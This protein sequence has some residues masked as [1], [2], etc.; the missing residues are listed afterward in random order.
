ME[1]TWPVKDKIRKKITINIKTQNS[2]KY[3][4]SN[5]SPLRQENLPMRGFPK[6]R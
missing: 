3:I 6:S 2:V 5:R 1:Q 4:K